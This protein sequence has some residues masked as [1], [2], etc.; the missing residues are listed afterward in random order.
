M[1]DRR[2]SGSSPGHYDLRTEPGDV[3]TA[4]D[5]L[6]AH[7][8]RHLVLLGS[9]L[10]TIA[11]ILAG[12]PGGPAAVAAG[13]PTRGLSARPCATVAVS[14]HLT[15]PAT[16]DGSGAAAALVSA[17]SAPSVAG[18]V[19]LAWEEG[20]PTVAGDA[21]QLRAWA[22]SRGRGAHVHPVP[23]TTDHSIALVQKHAD[24]RAFLIA[25]VRSCG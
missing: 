24:V 9:S 20:N 5:W 3:V 10:G 1:I 12:S 2:G 22:R 11:T 18:S 6:T 16:A 19:W 15:S 23:L 21:A 14:P 25:A 17:L 8:A 7:G 4:A 13:A